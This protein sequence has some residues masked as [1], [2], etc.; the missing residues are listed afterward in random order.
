M[1]H[2]DYF[3]ENK[4]QLNP[5]EKKAVRASGIVTKLSIKYNIPVK[6]TENL[7]NLIYQLSE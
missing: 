5:K 7:V 1:K 3:K 2:K 6:E 4:V